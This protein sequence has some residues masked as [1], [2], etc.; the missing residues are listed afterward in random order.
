MR[1]SCS[2][3]PRTAR[4]CTRAPAPGASRGPGPA[5]GRGGHG[6][7]PHAS[8]CCA[9]DARRA[10][11]P[12]TPRGSH[13]R[14]PATR[15]RRPGRSAPV[16]G[17]RPGRPP[18]GGPGGGKAPTG[19][20]ACRSTQ[21]TPRPAAIA[22]TTSTAHQRQPRPP[23]RAAPSSPRPSITNGNAVPSFRP[24]SPVRLKR[25][26]SRSRHPPPGRRR[27][28]PG[29]SAPGCRPLAG[30]RPP[31]AGRARRP[32][33]GDQP[34]GRRHRQRGQPQRQAPAVAVATPQLQAGT[35]SETSTAT[36]VS[37]SS[38]CARRAN[39]GPSAP[40]PQGRA[41]PATR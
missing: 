1:S 18:P 8:L 40:V 33:R 17:S 21:P 22:H 12:R 39:R 29:R 13:R 9:L 10:S 37:R 41:R 6:R 25:S 7:R 24:A 36:S 34:H 3:K 2:L 28:A 27:P 16:P 32:R 14:A 38:P 35:K 20:R 30:R 5:R 11:R 26:R 31:A 4:P 15:P 23:G 19:P